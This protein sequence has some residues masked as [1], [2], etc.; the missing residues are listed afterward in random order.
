MDKGKVENLCA[1]G[2]GIA[3]AYAA[4]RLFKRGLSSRQSNIVEDLSGEKEQEKI[5]NIELKKLADLQ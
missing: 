2:V 1:A 5:N 3:L 4:S